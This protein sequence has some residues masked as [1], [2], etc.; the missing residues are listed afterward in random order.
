MHDRWPDM[1]WRSA[2]G[3]RNLA[4][5]AY[6]EIEWSIVWRI[7]TASLPP[8]RDQLTALVKAEFPLVVD[9]LERKN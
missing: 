2:S 4:V 3:F 7:A 1:P 8:L 5:H 6:V 9:Q